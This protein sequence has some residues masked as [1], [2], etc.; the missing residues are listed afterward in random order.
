MHVRYNW[1]A[2]LAFKSHSKFI[3]KKIKCIARVADAILILTWCLKF[4]FLFN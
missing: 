3:N 1:R 2:L 4:S